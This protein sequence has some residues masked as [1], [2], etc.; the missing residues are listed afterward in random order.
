MREAR[1]E[2]CRVAT[3]RARRAERRAHT[4]ATMEFAPTR[5]RTTRPCAAAAII[6]SI[7]DS[8]MPATTHS[9][10]RPWKWTEDPCRAVRSRHGT[11]SGTATSPRRA[12]EALPGTA[13]PRPLALGSSSSAHSSSVSSPRITWAQPRPGPNQS[14]T[15]TPK[16]RPGAGLSP[17]R[18]LQSARTGPADRAAPMQGSACRMGRKRQCA[19]ML[20]V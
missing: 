10:N 13:H 3:D 1:E 20:G 2:A 6:A 19:A 17:L 7:G 4:R 11:G 16:A 15:A 14:A 8:T 18:A 12:A 5:D 9:G